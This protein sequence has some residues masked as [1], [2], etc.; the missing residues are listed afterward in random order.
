M[1]TRTAVK[2][3]ETVV[4]ILAGAWP[5][6]PCNGAVVV[7]GGPFDLPIPAPDA[8]GA[9]LGQGLMHDA[10]IKITDH[11]I[12]DDIDVMLNIQHTSAFDLQ[13]TLKNPAGS[14]CRLTS[15]DISNFFL[16]ADY[17]ATVFDD[18]ADTPIEQGRPPFTGR[19]RPLQGYSLT[20]FTGRD[21]FG[22]WRLKIYDAYE[23]DTGRLT[24]FQLII[25]TSAPEPGSMAIL[26]LGIGIAAI[27]CPRGHK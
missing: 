8:P 12:I 24:S 9:E 27:L 4:I 7:Y 5:L 19:F 18:K 14:V 2:W 20:A 17:I 3:I 26:I 13:I 25:T 6:C 15:P 16:G 1:E 10:I 23:Y 11:I 21:A 22:T